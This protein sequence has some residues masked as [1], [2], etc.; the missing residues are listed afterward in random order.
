[1][2]IKEH[3]IAKTCLDTFDI[4]FHDPI[5]TYKSIYIKRI[6]IPKYLQQLAKT[7]QFNKM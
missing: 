2:Q 4:R 6:P 5:E 1:M 3:K 7:S